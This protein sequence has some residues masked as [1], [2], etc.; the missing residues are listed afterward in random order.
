MER[1]SLNKVLQS[2]SIPC[3]VSFAI[4]TLL[5]GY[6]F[7]RDVAS[8][9][10]PLMKQF[11]FLT[12]LISTA[13]TFLCIGA[14]ALW[15]V[16]LFTKRGTDLDNSASAPIIRVA[17]WLVRYVGA[18]LVAMCLIILYYVLERFL[19]F[20]VI[21]F[22]AGFC[23]I[24]WV[25]AACSIARG[26][27]IRVTAKLILLTSGLAMIL[28]VRFLDWNS[29]KPFIRD[30]LTVRSGMTRPEVEAIMGRYLRPEW[31]DSTDDSYHGI[32]P[33]GLVVYR[34]SH[35]AAYNAD[36]GIVRFKNGRVD[37]VEFSSD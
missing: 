6:A 15:V 28:S 20:S 3:I 19:P 34:P 36:W 8:V 9:S 27:G 13:L 14:P 7:S 16:W 5:I 25:L 23:G 10:S 33:N 22:S 29:Q 32:D 4:P 2:A 35:E 31:E 17:D 11:G 24:L 18:A 26:S 30:L 21:P 1:N 37:G 12:W